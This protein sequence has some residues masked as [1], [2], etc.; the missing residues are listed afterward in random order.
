MFMHAHTAYMTLY[1]LYSIHTAYNRNTY[2]RLQNDVAIQ[3]LLLSLVD[4]N[5]DDD[6]WL[7]IQW[8]QSTCVV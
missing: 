8:N 3:L 4:D 2:K 5:D 6:F 7:L 1:C